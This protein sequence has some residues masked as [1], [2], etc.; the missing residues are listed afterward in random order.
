M[1][2]A[3]RT[4]GRWRALHQLA[5]R[6]TAFATVAILGLSAAHGVDGPTAQT[7]AGSKGFRQAM[8]PSFPKAHTTPVSGDQH[9]SARVSEA[10]GKLPLTFEENQG[11]FDKRVNFL[12]RGYGYALFLTSEGA[13][14]SLRRG[15]AR[16]E[17][18]AG[19]GNTGATNA[20]GADVPRSRR[21]PPDSSGVENAVVRMRLTRA[22]PDVEPTGI[23]E[24]PSRSNYLV[25]NDSA[26]WRSGVRGYAK[27]RY[28]GVL[29]GV[30]LV[31]YGTGQRQ[32]EYDLVVA[33]GADP[34]SIE[35]KFEGAERIAIEDAGELVLVLGDSEV[36]QPAPVVYQ[37]GRD[38]KRKLVAAKYSL[39]AGGAIGFEI[40]PYDRGQSLVIDP[41]LTYST[42][43]GGSSFGDADVVAAVAVDASGSVYVAGTAQSTN[44]PT[45][46]GAF[47]TTRSGGIYEAFVTKLS[48]SGSAL[49][50]S[51]YLGGSGDDLAQALAVDASGNVYVAGSTTSINY[52]T[53]VGAF[54]TAHVGGQDG[55]VTKLNSSGN[56]LLYSTY[57]GGSGDDKAQAAAVDAS[58]SIYV[59]GDTSSTN[60]PTTAGA[61]Q[62]TNA[63]GTSEGFVTKLNSSGSALVYSTY[64]GG[65]VSGTLANAAT[66]DASGN[67]YVAGET[68]AVYPTTAGA[69]Q[70]AY[71]G[72][73]DAFVTKLNASGSALVY[74]TFLGGSSEDLARSV[75]VDAS[76][77]VYV[78]GSTSS[79]NYPTT[80]GAFQ[81][82]IPAGG[83]GF[84]TKLN[85]SGSALVYSTFLG[86]GV[87][88]YAV[89]VDASGNVYV[90]GGANSTYPTTAGA[91]QTAEAGGEDAFLTM[92]NPSGSALVYSTYLGGSGDDY[93]Y[94]A[95]VDAGGN[96]YVA[97]GTNSTNY[98][99]T[100][101]AFRTGFPGAGGD[102]FVTKF[103]TVSPPVVPGSG[104][105]AGAV[106]GLLLALAGVAR[107]RRGADARE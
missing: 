74:S 80:A 82:G 84:V 64:L 7:I 101:G 63:S 73:Q 71:G 72:G 85:P 58:G 21:Q 106:L 47:Q 15:R 90:A 50:Y 53:T 57:L 59:A 39:R 97:G 46:A 68:F 33:P 100:A 78:A 61:F 18:S 65:G 34:R 86:G 88:A 17:P 42:Y 22:R 35:L 9:D 30:D 54:Q 6:A 26:N 12:A 48:P 89:A 11:Q 79:T 8:A 69:F 105:V 87:G 60:Y 4:P 55:F 107:T 67:V 40:G 37:P 43:L 98:P 19:T 45:T 32:L 49:V 3:T 38:G 93:A 14:L 13:T 51:T 29:P 103:A 1:T 95:A 2:T 41:T 76:G 77:N 66:V 31:Y 104:P 16:G 83:G 94:A 44:Y 91:F 81:T 25:G 52:P 99:T 20:H 24:Q 27:V 62:T 36:R 56:A 102:S 23:D 10:Y 92:M 28:S 75:A 70:T 96:A 5:L